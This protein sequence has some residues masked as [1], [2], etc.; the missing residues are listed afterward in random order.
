MDRHTCQRL[1]E[2]IVFDKTRTRTRARDL[3]R[4]EVEGWGGNVGGRSREG[5]GGG[6]GSEEEER[7]CDHFGREHE[8]ERVVDGGRDRS[9]SEIRFGNTRARIREV[10]TTSLST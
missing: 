1:L 9:L 10:A 6:E 4:D 8:R 3:P 5:E 7:G 2:V